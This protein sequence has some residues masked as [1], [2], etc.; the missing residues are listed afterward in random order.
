L[1]LSAQD[2]SQSSPYIEVSGTSEMDVVPDE[3]FITITLMERMEGK[4]KITIDKQETDLKK[5]LKELN[6]DLANLTLNN[7]NADYRTVRRKDKDVMIS[8][9]YVLKVSNTEALS[10]VYE[11]LDKMNAY[12][13]YISKYTCSKIQEFQKENRI[14]AIKAAQDKA[15]YLLVAIGQQAGQPIQITETENYVEDGQGGYRPM[16]NKMMLSNTVVAD[17]STT[18]EESI[19]FRKIKIRASFQA[20][21]LIVKK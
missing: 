4:E 20:K 5:N 21:F 3:L 18:S 12:D 8:K 14:K 11:R 2:A 16:M 13:A 6:I 7:A 1:W 19:S 9:S 17:G 10:K 15:T